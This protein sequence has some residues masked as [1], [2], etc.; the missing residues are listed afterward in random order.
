LRRAI[1]AVCAAA[2]SLACAPVPGEG[3]F[4]HID[5][6][7][8]LIIWDEPAQRQHF[9]RRASF[10]TDAKDFGFLVP[11]PAKPELAEADDGVFPTLA[12]I[13]APAVRQAA[14][15]EMAPKSLP[16]PAPATVTVLEQ[17]VVAGF[18]AAVL[19][20]S[21]AKALDG[22]LKAHGY[23]STPELV[24]WYEPYIARKWKITAFKIAAGAAKLS[25]AAVRMSF[26][27]AKPFFPYREPAA[28]QAPG[29]KPRDRLLRVYFLAE[30]RFGGTIG[31]QAPWPGTAV[32]SNAIETAQLAQLLKLAEL[33]PLAGGGGRRLTEFEDRSSPRPGADEV[34]FERAADQ[35][36]LERPAIYSGL[37]G[38]A[39]FVELV[40]LAAAILAILGGIWFLVRRFR[41]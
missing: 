27:T 22:W 36:T 34:F 12:E 4:V 14:K 35:S 8:A 9:I 18:D 15:G 5:T 11:T 23:L 10:E 13:T 2:P 17:K 31:E 19:E 16:A 25:T 29:T 32:W 26:Q 24:A 28:R 38:L 20:A 33:P 37:S 7:E 41:G 21:D 3:R 30:A 40:I 39:L 6:E 1:L